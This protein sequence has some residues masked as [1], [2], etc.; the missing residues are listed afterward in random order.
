MVLQPLKLHAP[1]LVPPHEVPS[2]L[3]EQVHAWLLVD[4]PQLPA[5]QVKLVQL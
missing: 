1:Q 4:E 3:R 5:A 2:V